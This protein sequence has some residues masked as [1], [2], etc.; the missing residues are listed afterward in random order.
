MNERIKVRLKKVSVN[1]WN[2]YTAIQAL[3]ENDNEV[4]YY[5]KN[6]QDAISQATCY[7]NTTSGTKF[8]V[9][10]GRNVWR[11][12][13]IDPTTNEPVKKSDRRYGTSY[14]KFRTFVAA[15]YDITH[16]EIA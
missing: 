6:R 1:E 2:G 15:L 11:R 5:M 13:S 7:V 16:I 14:Q 12:N 10:A 4:A 3:D 9:H 8:Y